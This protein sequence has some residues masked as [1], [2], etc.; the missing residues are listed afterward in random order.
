M[1]SYVLASFSLVSHFISLWILLQVVDLE[2]RIRFRRKWMRY[3]IFN[4]T[5]TRRGNISI[6][7]A[8]RGDDTELI[9]DREEFSNFKERERPY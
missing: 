4:G 1:F 5:E 7:T 9:K 8:P 3:F 2:D 6:C